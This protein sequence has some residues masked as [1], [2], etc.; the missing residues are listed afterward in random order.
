MIV[1]A[2]DSRV[3][4]M[5]DLATAMRRD[6]QSVSIAGGSAGGVEHILAGLV[7]R[8]VG[9]DPAEVNYVAHSGGGEALTTVLSGLATA[10][11]SGVSEL[12]PQ[13]RAGNIRAL[14]VSSPQRLPALPDVPTL[15]EAGVDVELENWRAVVAPAGITED[16]KSTLQDLI[17][18]MTRSEA[19]ADTL[20]RRGWL[21]AT[22]AGPE[23]DAFLE[24]E[25]RRIA[26]VI[27]E[28]GIG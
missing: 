1:V 10:A 2:K 16:E 20:E 8:A 24:A 6:L 11:V 28:M 7:A 12:A 25:Q 19:W 26:Q 14:A 18:Q 22:L 23:F 5:Q 13:I 4:T 27:A 21:D 3:A 15:R 17:L 9:G